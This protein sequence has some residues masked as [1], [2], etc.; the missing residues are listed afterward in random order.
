MTCQPFSLA[1]V[2]LRQAGC[3][4]ELWTLTPIPAHHVNLYG[5]V[6][7]C[8]FFLYTSK[9]HTDIYIIYHTKKKAIALFSWALSATREFKKYIL[10]CIWYNG[11]V[12]ASSKFLIY[13]YLKRQLMIKRQKQPHFSKGKEHG[14]IYAVQTKDSECHICTGQGRTTS[15]SW[16]SSELPERIVEDWRSR[17]VLLQERF[18]A[19]FGMK[20]ARSSN[21]MPFLSAKDLWCQCND[22]SQRLAWYWRIKQI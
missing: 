17:G 7:F 15:C 14:V 2:H 13:H 12:L 5:I 22:G 18:W 11:R 3:R 9:K 16:D 19:L 20:G 1:C 8:L 6:C 4:T 10:V 21:F